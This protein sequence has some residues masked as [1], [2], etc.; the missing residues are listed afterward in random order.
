M[1][2]TVDLSYV[3]TPILCLPPTSRTMSGATDPYRIL[4]LPRNATQ[5]QLS[6][7]FSE[8]AK[9]LHP[10]TAR[11]ATRAEEFLAVKEAYDLLRTPDRRREFDSKIKT[12]FEEAPDPAKYGQRTAEFDRRFKA[13]SA[14][15]RALMNYAPSQSCCDVHCSDPFPRRF[16]ASARVRQG[17]SHAWTVLSTPTARLILMPSA[18]LVRDMPGMGH[19]RLLHTSIK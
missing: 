5:A 10:D 16:A 11:G 7:A 14:C 13:S 4:G 17:L 6:H 1:H 2:T 9:E 18:L 15:T 3:Y 19:T 8:L 12:A